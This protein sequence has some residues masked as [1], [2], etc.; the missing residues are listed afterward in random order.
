M[1]CT[2][3]IVWVFVAQAA[4]LCGRCAVFLLMPKSERVG[5][6]FSGGSVLVLPEE[7]RPLKLL[8]V[9]FALS[10]ALRRLSD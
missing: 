1:G 9:P 10:V 3:C 5:A 4:C 7:S 8:F 2:I 6:S